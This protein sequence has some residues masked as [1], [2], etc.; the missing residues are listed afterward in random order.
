MI[1]LRAGLA[2]VVLILASI[3]CGSSTSSSSSTSGAAAWNLVTP[4]YL[5]VANSGTLNPGV[6][7]EPG[8]QLGGLD[9]VLLTRFLQ[10]NNLKL[11]IIDVP[12]PSLV[13]T[14][15][16][17]KADVGTYLLW[18]TP[19]AQHVYYTDPW[20]RD[21]VSVFTLKT[22]NYTGPSSLLGKKLGTGLGYVWAPYMQQWCSSCVQ[23]FP[24]ETV[25]QQALLDGIIQGYLDGSSIKIGPPMN[26]AMD[27]VNEH[28]VNT[29]DY[30]LPA[31]SINA[32][33]YNVTNCSQGKALASALNQEYVKITQENGGSSWL[34]QL[35]GWTLDARAMAPAQA[36][37]QGC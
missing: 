10:D 35:H 24:N 30:N 28:V 2:T 20:F 21:P 5:T 23:L 14:I 1:N 15:E 27:R 36:P 12:F 9:G 33:Y 29:G 8:N 13:L 4:G 16:Q 7:E 22:F 17:H 11:K 34:G 31:E 37:A 6:V 26:G 32:L 25:G 19:R 3:S 18:S